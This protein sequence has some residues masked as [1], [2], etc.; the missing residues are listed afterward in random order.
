MLSPS[1]LPLS[2]EYKG[3]GKAQQIAPSVSPLP[4][5]RARGVGGEGGRVSAR[6][7]SF[8]EGCY[9]PH[10]CPSPPS[11]RE[12]G[13]RNR[14]RLRSPL[15]PVLGGEGSG[16]RGA[17]SVQERRVFARDAIPLTPAPLPRVQGRG[18]SATDRAFGLPSPLYSGE[19]GRG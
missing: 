4:C 7:S 15:S 16:V 19:R 11:T 2:P 3:E 1:P 12:R 8:R 6:T 9:P 14:S 13:K 5:T 17:G 18:E 10:P